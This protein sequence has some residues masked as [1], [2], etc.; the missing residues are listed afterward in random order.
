MAIH[1]LHN[2]TGSLQCTHPVVASITQ[3][4]PKRHKFAV[5]TVSWFPSDS[6]MFLTSGMDCLMKVWD[7]NTLQVYLNACKMSTSILHASP[8]AY[9]AMCCLR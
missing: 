9:K 8:S 2:T 7:T 3:E 5:E 6:G 4:T 1:D